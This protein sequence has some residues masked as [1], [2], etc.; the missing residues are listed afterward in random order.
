MPTLPFAENPLE[1]LKER[2]E[3]GIRVTPLCR[4]VLG[5]LCEMPTNP[6]IDEISVRWGQVS[7]R[8][9]DETTLIPFGSLIEFLNQIKVV[10]E[11]LS[12]THAQTARV[13][14]WAR[15]QLG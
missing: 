8:L 9:T 13:I 5:W 15:H 1:I 6:S 10:C 12:L 3:S 2:L 11:A 7:L 4:A 14:S